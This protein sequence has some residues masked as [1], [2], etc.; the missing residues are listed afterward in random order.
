MSKIEK[1]APFEM[2]R[3]EIGKLRGGSSGRYQTGGGVS[4]HTGPG[5]QG[6]VSYKF[7]NDS[8]DAD[9]SNTVSPQSGDS[10]EYALLDCY[11]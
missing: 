4:N 10:A 2:N 1:L 8:C 3:M 11:D 6:T 9:G 7:S 5:G